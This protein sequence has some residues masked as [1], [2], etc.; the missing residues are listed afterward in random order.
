MMIYH[1]YQ[2]EFLLC[3]NPEEVKMELFR[4]SFQCL[5]FYAKV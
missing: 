2:K 4:E 5:L 1:Q 3:Q